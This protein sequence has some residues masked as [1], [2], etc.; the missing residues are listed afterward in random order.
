MN[1]WNTICKD[2]LDKKTKQATEKEYQELVSLYR[3]VRKYNR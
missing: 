2:I 1:I 3:V